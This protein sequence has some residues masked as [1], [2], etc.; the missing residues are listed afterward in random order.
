MARI[1]VVSFNI[2]NVNGVQNISLE[3]YANS[4]VLNQPLVFGTA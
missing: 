1:R 2:L 4:I 3:I